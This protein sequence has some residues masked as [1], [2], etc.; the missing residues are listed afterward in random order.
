MGRRNLRN[1][2][3][4]AEQTA[5]DVRT[6]NRFEHDSSLHALVWSIYDDSVFAHAVFALEAEPDSIPNPACTLDASFLRD[7]GTAG[8]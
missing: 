2:T 6:A 8:I 4:L 1:N 5:V 3:W 7:D